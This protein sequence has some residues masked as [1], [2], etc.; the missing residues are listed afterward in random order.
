MSDRV[1]PW[2]DH[3][4]PKHRGKR[5]RHKHV[6]DYHKQREEFTDRL[7]ITPPKDVTDGEDERSS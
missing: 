2:R 7:W 3:R 5:P 1:R 4:I 6:M